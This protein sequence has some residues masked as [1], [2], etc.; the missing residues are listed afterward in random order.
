VKGI[1]RTCLLGHV[2]KEPTIRTS[3]N[4]LVV[5]FSLA[6]SEPYKD[7]SD[8]WQTRAEWHNLV[9]FGRIAEIV[10]DHVKKGAEL[11]VEGRLRTRSWNDQKTNLKLYITEILLTELIML[12]AKDKRASS[13]E[14]ERR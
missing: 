11:Y 7:D 1:N 6:T 13:G 3:S 9:A 12:G 4:G 10:R 14:K 8:T 5:S 2:G